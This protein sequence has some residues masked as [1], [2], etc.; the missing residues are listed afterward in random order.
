MEELENRDKGLFP[1]P[2][3]TDN[4]VQLVSVTNRPSVVTV[5]SQNPS[6]EVSRASCFEFDYFRALYWQDS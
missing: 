1:V 3:K 6:N 4:T 2:S 5:N